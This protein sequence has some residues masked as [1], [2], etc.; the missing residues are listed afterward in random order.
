MPVAQNRHAPLTSV[1][2]SAIDSHQDLSSTYHDDSKR[3]SI[4]STNLGQS[5]PSRPYSPGM[6]SMSSPKVPTVEE[7]VV[8]PG[9]IQMQNFADGS[10][11]PPPPSHS[12]KKIERWVEKNYP[13]LLD[14]MCE[15][16]SQNDI[17]E[18]EHDLD[19]TLPQDIRESLSI[20]DGQE[21]GGR[22]AG[23]IFSCMLLDCEE[24]VQE[25]NQWKVVN[26]E[27]LSGAKKPIPHYPLKGLNAGS[28]SS[29]S[30]HSQ[31]GTNK[32]WRQELLDRQDSQ[33]PKAIQKAYA[34]PSWIPLAR[35]WGGNNIAVDL[36]PGP[37]GKW[38]QIIIFGRD[39]DCKYVVARSWSH[40]LA[41]V[42]DDMNSDRVSVDEDSGE[43]KL[44]EF[45]SETV[46]PNYLEILR[47]RA[48]QKYG[49]RGSSKTRQAPPG[50]N[51]NVNGVN[52]RGSPYGSPV[53]GEERGRSPN[54]FSRSGTGSPRHTIG[55]P[56]ARVQEEIAQPYPV[57]PGGD[58]V[59]DFAAIAETTGNG[60]EKE[61]LVEAP[62]PIETNVKAMQKNKLVDLPTPSS[63]RGEKPK[64]PSSGLSRVG[65]DSEGP[66][67]IT[68]PLPSRI[69]SDRVE[70]LGVNGV[71]DEMKNVS[72]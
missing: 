31:S 39:Y 17:N 64:F 12:W 53:G 9:E 18:L 41:V 19:M 66:D 20:H 52:S 48:D 62:T 63:A 43:M 42:A 6:R 38:G 37:M 59:R 46:E 44:K 69:N 7:A 40:F 60:K 26:E 2:T 3:P 65:T 29:S 49:R 30:S 58:V 28:S 45:K 72:I 67:T 27:Y 8:S 10:P 1:A 15:G 54:R 32:L 55:S 13:E 47:W 57:R 16:C 33:P 51:T 50:L 5:S 34:H 24:I 23:V 70:G 35:D 4:S 71:E 56:L 21:R 11:P 14:N 61:K 22:P 36:A 25:W 68:K